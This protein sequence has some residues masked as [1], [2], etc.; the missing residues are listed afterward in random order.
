MNKIL[1]KVWVE[2][3]NRSLRF[4]STVCGSLTDAA[5]FLRSQVGHGEKLASAEVPGGYAK[6]VYAMAGVK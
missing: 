2:T 6:R 4:N 5:R 3:A 1:V